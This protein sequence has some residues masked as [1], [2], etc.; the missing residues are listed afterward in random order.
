[1]M[2]ESKNMSLQ[3]IAPEIAPSSLDACKMLCTSASIGVNSY[4]YETIDLE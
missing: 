4:N 3:Y 1:M 2:K